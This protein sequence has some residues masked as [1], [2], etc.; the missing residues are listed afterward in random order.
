[1]TCIPHALGLLL[2][3]SR[4]DYNLL[5]NK[6]ASDRD[7]STP[8]YEARVEVWRYENGYCDLLAQSRQSSRKRQVIQ[9]VIIKEKVRTNRRQNDGKCYLILQVIPLGYPKSIDRPSFV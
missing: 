3:L 6:H 1:M 9:N 5:D 2:F 8:E 7:Q 4:L